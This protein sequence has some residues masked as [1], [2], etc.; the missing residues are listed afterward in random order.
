MNARARHAFLVGET[1]TL[2]PIGLRIHAR[3][4]D[5]ANAAGLVERSGVH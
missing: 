4:R 1:L 3:R 5:P 2:K